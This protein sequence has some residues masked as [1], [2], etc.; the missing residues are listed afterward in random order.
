MAFKTVKKSA[1]VSGMLVAAVAAT[2]ALATPASASA[3]F[4]CTDLGQQIQ[5]DQ[6]HV[7]ESTAQ[8]TVPPNPDLVL[9]LELDELAF[10]SSHCNE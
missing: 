6:E 2:V 8:G 10:D 3:T 9:R 4:T 7:N 5:L 1:L